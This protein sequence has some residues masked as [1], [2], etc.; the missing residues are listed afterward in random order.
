MNDVHKL[1][2]LSQYSR[3]FN[4]SGLV[5]S[6]TKRYYSGSIGQNGFGMEAMWEESTEQAHSLRSATT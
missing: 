3:H 5:W 1:S 4:A 6:Q 2:Q